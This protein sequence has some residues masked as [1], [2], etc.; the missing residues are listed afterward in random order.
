MFKIEQISLPIRGE[1]KLHETTLKSG[2]VVGKFKAG[3]ILICD[4]SDFIT[5]VPSGI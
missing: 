1:T 3:I 5:A 4:R 2:I